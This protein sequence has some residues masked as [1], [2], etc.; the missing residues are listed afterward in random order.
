M[1]LQT[2]QE[3]ETLREGLL[4]YLHYTVKPKEEEVISTPYDV[5]YSLSV[6]ERYYQVK[7]YYES[8]YEDAQ[9]RFEAFQNDEVAEKYL[10]ELYYTLYDY[11]YIQANG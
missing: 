4:M 7:E 1:T 6:T 5:D 8:D 9:N 11:F 3:I 2:K 10:G